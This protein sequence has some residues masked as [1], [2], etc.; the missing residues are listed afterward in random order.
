MTDYSPNEVKLPVAGHGGAKKGEVQQMVTRILGLPAPR[1]RPT[2]PTPSPSRCAIG[3][4]PDA[5][6]GRGGRAGPAAGGSRLDAA[7]GAAFAWE[8]AK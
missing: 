6:G 2:P 7:I 8:A 3:G 1:A 4:G 5:T